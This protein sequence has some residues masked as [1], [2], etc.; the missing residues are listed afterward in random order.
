[1]LEARAIG[2][3]APVTYSDRPSEEASSNKTFDAF[4]AAFDA[5]LIPAP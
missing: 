4:D 1:M 3:V 5:L 2:G